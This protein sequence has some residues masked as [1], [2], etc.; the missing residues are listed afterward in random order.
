MLG[1]LI[2]A[3]PNFEDVYRT[4]ATLSVS[5]GEGRLVS[6]ELGVRECVYG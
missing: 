2:S 5:Y 1:I 4:M 3:T 6:E